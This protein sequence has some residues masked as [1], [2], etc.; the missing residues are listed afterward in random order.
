MG[1]IVQTKK[2]NFQA[3]YAVTSQY[4]LLKRGSLPLADSAQQASSVPFLEEAG[5]KRTNC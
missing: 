5:T 3:G 4:E 1:F 2:G